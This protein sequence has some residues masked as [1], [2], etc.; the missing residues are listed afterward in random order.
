MAQI[1]GLIKFI[2]R[3]FKSVW[4]VVIVE[5]ICQTDKEILIFAKALLPANKELFIT[6]LGYG[7]VMRNST[8]GN[9]PMI[10]LFVLIPD[11][12]NF[13]SCL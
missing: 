6:I 3:M 1:V 9:T 13:W 7:E 10:Y 12:Q 11:H 8:W 5:I 4:Q 2:F